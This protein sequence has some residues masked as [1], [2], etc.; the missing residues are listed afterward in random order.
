MKRWSGPVS[1]NQSDA[2]FGEI[3][4]ALLA[5]AKRVFG[6]LLVFDVGIGAVPFDDVA[7]FVTQ[8]LGTAQEPAIFAVRSADAFDVLVG[9][10]GFHGDA[11]LVRHSCALVRMH[12]VD[13]FGALEIIQRKADF[14]PAP[15]DEIQRA[16]RQSAPDQGRNRIDGK[17]KFP[18]CLFG[19][20]FGL[21]RCFRQLAG[22]SDQARHRQ[23]G[24]QEDDHQ[25]DILRPVAHGT[26]NR[27]GKKVNQAGNSHE[28]EKNRCQVAADQGQ[29][30]DDGQINIRR[31]CE[32]RLEPEADKGHHCQR[33]DSAKT[34]RS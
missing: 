7:E 29:Q 30:H 16:V 5:L 32:I 26:E 33:N 3:A 1:H 34:L 10:P 13:P 28:N 18:C 22:A 9:S 4:E 19:D 20:D 6:T 17:P 27:R 25:R 2:E 15:V 11:P 12:H 8:R 24:Q 21:P 31:R 14:L 23:W